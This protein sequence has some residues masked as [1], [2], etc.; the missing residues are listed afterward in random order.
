M[1]TEPTP[2]YLIQSEVERLRSQFSQTQD[3]YRE[4]CVLLFFRFGI[5]PTA[6]RLYQFV[7]KGSMS[8]PAEAL[9]KFWDNL[10][11]K[12]RVRIEHPDL[13]EGLRDA[14]GK[15]TATL[16]D[17]ARKAAF[18]DISSYKA[19]AQ[20]TVDEAK[21]CQIAAEAARD[22]ALQRLAD[23]ELALRNATE[24]NQL[25]EL[26]IAAESATVASLED[27]IDQGSRH[28]NLL[29]KEL[30][31]AH[32]RFSNDLE[33]LRASL[34]LAE[35]RLQASEHRALL[36]IDRERTSVVR[37]QKEFDK[38]KSA[39]ARADEQQRNKFA[40]LQTE[41]DGLRTINGVLEGSLQ[42]ITKEKLTVVA[43]LDVLRTKLTDALTEAVQWRAEATGWQRQSSDALKRRRK[44]HVEDASF[45]KT[46]KTN[47]DEDPVIRKGRR[48]SAASR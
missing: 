6:N 23:S 29:Q 25:L 40:S 1:T 48:P 2:E 7:R 10:R 44:S 17:E 15:L 32:V 20:A 42:E 31:Q 13:P 3:L 43:E 39:A 45:S 41:M 5:T 24:S 26:R 21:N 28:T 47:T 18:T 36:E 9:A 12:S 35:E 4:V 14:A 11:E 8:A 22:D 16:W 27:Q 37:I 38:A 46:A 34:Q 30:E 19:D 33:K